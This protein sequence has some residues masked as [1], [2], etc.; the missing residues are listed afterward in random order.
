M[1]HRAGLIWVKLPTVRS[2]TRVNGPGI[3]PGGGGEEWAVL[4][5]TGTL[6]TICN[7]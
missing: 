1:P 5:L 3:A 7:N 6:M 4:E 2:L